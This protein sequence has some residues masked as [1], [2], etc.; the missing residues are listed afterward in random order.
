M[1]V[2]PRRTI[3]RLED[4]RIGIVK[5]ENEEEIFSP[6]VEIVDG[7]GKELVDLKINKEV[8]IKQSLNPLTEGKNYVN[9]I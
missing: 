2:W 7:G 5:Q 3:V 6:I 8:K 4:G 1:G 9:L